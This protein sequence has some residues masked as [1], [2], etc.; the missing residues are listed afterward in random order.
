MSGVMS[1]EAAMNAATRRNMHLVAAAK[2]L[3]PYDEMVRRET[4]NYVL[5]EQA[6][7]EEGVGDWLKWVW[8]EGPDP[9]AAFMRF[10]S[11]TRGVRPEFLLNMSGEEIASLFNQG[12]GAESAR[13]RRVLSGTL[14]KAG[15]R[16]TTLPF[17]KSDTARQKYAAVQKGNSN[18]RKRG[19]KSA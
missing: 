10:I 14:E 18:R 9:K 4:A 3:T 19:K 17:Q 1:P 13:S 8:E 12:R 6:I 11:F 7:R 16:C 15:N 5:E 2:T